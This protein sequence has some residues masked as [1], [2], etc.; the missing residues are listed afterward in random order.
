MG[1]GTRIVYLCKNEKG[2]VQNS[3]LEFL[4]KAR[5]SDNNN[6][7]GGN[8][9]NRNSVSHICVCSAPTKPTCSLYCN[10]AEQILVTISKRECITWHN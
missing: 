10:S 2:S 3:L 7:N 9:Q 4:M 5:H 6:K 8:S 1:T